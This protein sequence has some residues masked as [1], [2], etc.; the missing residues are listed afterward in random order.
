MEGFENIVANSRAVFLG[1]LW[2]KRMICMYNYIDIL[3]I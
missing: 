2:N 1:R 3:D